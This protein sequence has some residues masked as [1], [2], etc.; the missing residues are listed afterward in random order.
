MVPNG[1]VVRAA[2]VRPAADL[3]RGPAQQL[4]TLVLRAAGLRADA[5]A[6]PFEDA[7]RAGGVGSRAGRDVE[8]GAD[9]RSASRLRSARGRSASALRHRGEHEFC[10][11]RRALVVPVRA[12]EDAEREA[13]GRR[14]RRAAR[15]PSR[16]RGRLPGGAA[17]S[18]TA[19]GGSLVSV[20]SPPAAQPRVAALPARGRARPRDRPAVEVPFHRFPRVFRRGGG[21]APG[22]ALRGAGGACRTR[23]RKASMPSR[24][25]TNFRRALSLFVRFP[26][27]E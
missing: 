7:S 16:P 26:S 12:G 17:R 4:E 22:R 6:S 3:D 11:R 21:A 13:A 27:S 20:A 18:W 10:F 5:R 1:D 24:A 9:A 2:R 8:R 19:S 25:T 23:S 15:A 14:D